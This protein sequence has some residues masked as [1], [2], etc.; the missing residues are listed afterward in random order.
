MTSKGHYVPCFKT[1]APWCCQLFI[2]S[3]TFNLLLDNEWLQQMSDLMLA[4]PAFDLPEPE[5]KNNRRIIGRRKKHAALHGFLVAARLLLK[6][7]ACVV[8]LVIDLA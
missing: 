1:H 3:F 2:F 4:R 5:A 7:F 8:C 6:P